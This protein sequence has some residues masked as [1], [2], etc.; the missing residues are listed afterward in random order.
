MAS[1]VDCASAV[2]A[3]TTSL[4]LTSWRLISAIDFDNSSAAAAALS[5]PLNASFDVLTAPSVCAVVS[6]RGRRQRGR[7]RFHRRNAVGDGLEDALD[8]VAEPGDGV[9]DD[10]AARFLLAEQSALSVPPRGAR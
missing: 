7:G 10:G 4:A 2:A 6:L 8:A 3:R 5:T 9:V 1:L